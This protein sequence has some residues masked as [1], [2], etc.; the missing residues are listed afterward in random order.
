MPVSGYFVM[1]GL[2]IALAYGDIVW[3]VLSSVL[4]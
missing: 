3:A 2:I 1:A 4:K